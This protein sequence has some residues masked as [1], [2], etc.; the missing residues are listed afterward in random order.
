M[1]KY[2]NDDVDEEE[3]E[4]DGQGGDYDFKSLL[5]DVVNLAAGRSDP[6]LSLAL[7]AAKTFLAISG[8]DEKLSKAIILKALSSPTVSKSIFYL[9][10]MVNKENANILMN[11]AIVFMIPSSNAIVRLLGV[12]TI[13]LV[14]RKLD[15]EEG[16]KEYS[17]IS[18]RSLLN[19]SDLKV[20]DAAVVTL[21]ALGEKINKKKTKEAKERLKEEGIDIEEAE[22]E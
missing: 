3:T 12:I 10:S 5:G 22:L 20:R 8:Y 19:D 11:S 6:R 15:L 1:N 21:E 13:S 4:R 18:L 2:D 9:R 16:T 7:G 14:N 17:K